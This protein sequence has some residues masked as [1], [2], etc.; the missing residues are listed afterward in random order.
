VILAYFYSAQPN[1]Y[2]VCVSDPILKVHLRRCEYLE[3]DNLGCLFVSFSPN[4]NGLA[5]PDP[6]LLGLHATCARVAH[7]SGAA[8]AFDKV[9]RNLENAMVLASDRSSAHLIDH[10]LVPFEAIPEVV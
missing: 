4:D 7:M 9:E 6:R 3:S 1:C 10:L 8:E 2:Q 5:L